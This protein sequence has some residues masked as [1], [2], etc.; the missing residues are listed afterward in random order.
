MQKIKANELNQ[1]LLEGKQI[2][3]LDLRESIEYETDHIAGA[4]WVPKFK[5]KR[6]EVT[7]L[8]SSKCIVMY[9]KLGL[10]CMEHVYIMEELGYK[11]IYCLEGGVYAWKSEVNPDF[12]IYEYY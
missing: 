12:N 8:D 9:C 3:L 7:G 4:I 11:D 6:K 1:W 10:S 2:Q 5:I